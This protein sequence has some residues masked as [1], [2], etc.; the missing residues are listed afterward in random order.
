MSKSLLVFSF[1]SS[2]RLDP[3]IRISGSKILGVIHLYRGT[4]APLGTPK[5][6]YLRFEC[7][8]ILRLYTIVLSHCYISSL[9]IIRNLIL[10]GAIYPHSLVS[11][12]RWYYSSLYHPTG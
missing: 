10:I 5:G 9:S 7:S 1:T 2:K 6:M 12:T 4:P 11:N 3:E 8:N